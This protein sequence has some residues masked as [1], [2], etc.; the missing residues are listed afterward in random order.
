MDISNSYLTKLCGMTWKID[1]TAAVTSN[2]ILLLSD[3]N[4]SINIPVT[5]SMNTGSLIAEQIATYINQG[6]LTGWSAT[7]TPS[8]PYLF[9]YTSYMGRTI[10]LAPLLTGV[11]ASV[12]AIDLNYRESYQTFASKWQGLNILKID[13]FDKRGKAKNIY[14]R[15]HI[16]SSE[17]DVYIP[18]TVYFEQPDIDISFHIRDF[19]NH[20]IDV[21]AIHVDFIN[22]MTTHRYAIKSLYTGTE[23]DFVCLKDYDPMLIKL[24]RVAG[25]NVILGTITVHRVKDN[26]V[27]P[28]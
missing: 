23:S 12:T 28:N 21:E 20:T 27:V 25:Q 22:Y 15:S 2:G 10:S 9:L 5:T 3:G 11:I 4:T 6:N 13:N 26:T 14:T 18:D 16:N 17:E 24:K 8:S 1:I 7:H 19:Y